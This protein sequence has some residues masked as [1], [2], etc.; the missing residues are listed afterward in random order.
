MRSK[1]GHKKA[2]NNYLIEA[3]KDGKT[4]YFDTTIEAGDF[5]GCSH[6]LVVKAL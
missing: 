6:V 4:F 2:R 3:T 5:I 1:N